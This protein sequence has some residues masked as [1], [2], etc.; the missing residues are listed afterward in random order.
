MLMGNTVDDMTTYQHGQACPLDINAS[1]RNCIGAA[2]RLNIILNL[3]K[4]V[5]RL[6]NK[7]I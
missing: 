4:I 2:A 7:N 6:S 3:Q 5:I 1:I